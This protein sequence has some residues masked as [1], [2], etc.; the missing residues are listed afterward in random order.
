[1]NSQLK[2][3]FTSSPEME[4]YMAKRVCVSA[5]VKLFNEEK[6]SSGG[7]EM[8]SSKRNSLARAVTTGG[9]LNISKKKTM[10]S[11]GT[12]STILMMTATATPPFVMVPHNSLLPAEAALDTI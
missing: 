5:S 8:V 11:I 9:C 7:V 6:I 3:I 2:S 4:M 1:M 12:M 10:I